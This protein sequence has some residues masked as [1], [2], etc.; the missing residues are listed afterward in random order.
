MQPSTLAKRVFPLIFFGIFIFYLYGLGH[1]PLVGPDEPRYAQVAREMFL[2]HDWITPTLGGHTWFEKPALL[3]WM[4]IGAFKTFG[5][6][7]WSARLG[8]AIC[9]LLTIAAVW[10][11]GSRVEYRGAGDAVNG[12]GLIGAFVAATSLGL[13]VFSRGASFDIVITVTISWALGFFLAQ[14]LTDNSRK[15]NL[16]LA[17]FYVFVGLSL[18]GKGLV[19]IVIPFGVVTLYY[20]LRRELPDSLVRTSLLWGGPLAVLVAGL[21]YGPVIAK[22]GQTFIDQF[23]IQHHFARYLSNKYHHPQPLY[24]YLPVIALLALPWTG[25]L[26]DA[27]VNVRSWGW[28]NA[29]ATSKTRVFALSWLILPILFF[30]FSGSKLPGYI[31]PALPA[32]SLLIGVSLVQRQSRWAMRVTGVLCLTLG[33]VGA[34]YATHTHVLSA[35][36]AFIITAPLL[37]AGV[38]AIVWARLRMESMISVGVATML[39]LA[40]VLHSVAPTVASSESVRDLLVQADARGY[41][42]APVFARRGDDR[43]AEFYADGRVVYDS[44][45]EPVVL[46]EIAAIRNEAIRRGGKVLVIVPAYYIEL[47]ERLPDM[48]VIGTNGKVALIG[49]RGK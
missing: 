18:I 38:F 9:G 13:I 49:V 35:S 40:L 7:E 45:G 3:Y 16:W 1:L 10:F 12:Q 14:E 29:D 6:N 33:I 46:D 44:A 39:T 43:T 5:V 48:E 20:A 32:V 30:S 42:Q 22:H 34:V 41:G 31:L 26:I 36:R 23:F 25:A 19:G 15:R 24:F 17:G 8:P 47:V 27:L 37:A 21:W 4:M 2:R 11:A 28:R